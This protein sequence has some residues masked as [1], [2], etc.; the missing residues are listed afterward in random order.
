VRHLYLLKAFQ[1]NQLGGS[2]NIIALAKSKTY[3]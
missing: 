1:C 2:G 3:G